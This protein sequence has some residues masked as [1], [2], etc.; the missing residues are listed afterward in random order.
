MCL[1]KTRKCEYLMAATDICMMAALHGELLFPTV[2][3][4]QDHRALVDP[5][6]ADGLDEGEDRHR[7]SR[8]GRE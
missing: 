2:G 3:R 8:V 1:M 4:E 6:Q 5:D 7:C